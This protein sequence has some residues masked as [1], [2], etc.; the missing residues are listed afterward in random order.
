MTAPDRIWINKFNGRNP[1]DWDFTDGKYLTKAQLR[2]KVEYIRLD[3]AVLAA[4]PEVM[5]LIDA[6]EDRLHGGGCDCGACL[7]LIEALAPF[8]ATIRKGADQ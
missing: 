2:Q 6:A 3:P 4:L 8:A 7:P 5:A 1:D